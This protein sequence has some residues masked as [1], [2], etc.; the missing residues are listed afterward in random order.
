MVTLPPIVPLPAS[1]AAALD[2]HRRVP[3]HAV[4][5][6]RAGRDRRRACVGARARQDQRARAV[7]AQVARAGNNAGER[8]S[9][10]AVKDEVAIVDHI[11]NNAAAG[12]PVANL[13]R[14]A[15][16]S[17][18]RNYRNDRPRE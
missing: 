18:E 9:I 1:V 8:H 16:R 5:L 2:R 3:Q 13:Q 17:I 4:Y 15:P 10:A 11:S 6:Q 12:S 14:S 7:L